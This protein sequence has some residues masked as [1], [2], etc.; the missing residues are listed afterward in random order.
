MS[1]LKQSL[2]LRARKTRSMVG[3][4]P[5]TSAEI[6]RRQMG[7]T[8]QTDGRL[9]KTLARCLVGPQVSHAFRHSENKYCLFT[10]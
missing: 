4:R 7:V 9:R 8:E 3:T 2:G 10:D 6:M 5:M 1:R